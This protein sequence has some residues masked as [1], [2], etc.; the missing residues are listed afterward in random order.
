MHALEYF[1]F[2]KA[3]AITLCYVTLQVH[4]ET[5]AYISFRFQWDL[6]MVSNKVDMH[7]YHFYIF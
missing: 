2:E 5:L 6:N 3:S 1:T 4:V 7:K